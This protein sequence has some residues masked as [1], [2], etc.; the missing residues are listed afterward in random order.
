MGSRLQRIQQFGNYFMNEVFPIL[1]GKVHHLYSHQKDLGS[2]FAI[3]LG[4]CYL[5]N[6]LII[7]NFISI[8]RKNNSFYLTKVSTG[9]KNLRR[10]LGSDASVSR[11]CSF[12]VFLHIRIVFDGFEDRIQS[13]AWIKHRLSHQ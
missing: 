4:M 5:K 8:D 13:L 7:Y 1:V 12:P 9:N 11:A 2:C 3:R 10:A 6:N